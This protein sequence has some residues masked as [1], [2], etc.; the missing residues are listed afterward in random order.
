MLD[1]V[2]YIPDG[3]YYRPR[4]ASDATRLERT[5]DG[6]WITTDGQGIKRFYGLSA[7]SR[8]ADPDNT[9]K[10]F[11][12]SLERILL[13]TGEH[14]DYQYERDKGAV[15]PISVKWA[16][17]TSGNALYEARLVYVPKT[18]SIA[19]YRTNFPV[20]TARLLSE[21]GLYVQGDKKRFYTLQYDATETVDSHLI[22]VTESTPEGSLPS[23]QFT[24]YSGKFAH[25]LSSVVLPQ[26]AKVDLTYEPS[27]LL[28]TVSGA[29]ANPKLPMNLMVLTGIKVS[30]PVV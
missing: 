28:K 22:K 23:T 1:G 15:Y 14:V 21:V 24:Y 7:S 2:E 16:F 3:T 11:S 17:N 29:Q 26:G 9:N 25:F 6:G 13:P 10:V 5:N 30:E 18:R 20:Q 12:W 8:L 27:A 4:F 19:S